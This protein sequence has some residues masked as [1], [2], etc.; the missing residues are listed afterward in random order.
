V[1]I[2]PTHV[3][4]IAADV[5]AAPAGDGAVTASLAPGTEVAV[6][7]VAGDWSLIARNGQLVGYIATA[8]L[9]A[10]K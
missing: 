7:S 9:A 2:A 1:V 5:R 3:V 4:I 10:L 6:L 8:N